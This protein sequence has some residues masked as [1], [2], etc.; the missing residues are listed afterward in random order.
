MVFA[1]AVLEMV[2]DLQ[3]IRYCR[4]IALVASLC[5]ELQLKD[6]AVLYPHIVNWELELGVQLARQIF[7]TSQSPSFTYLQVT[8]VFTR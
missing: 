1:T 4:D 8:L 6:I 3:Q 2:S 5:L 7:T